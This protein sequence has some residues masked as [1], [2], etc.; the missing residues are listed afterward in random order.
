MQA[1]GS[2]TKTKQKG[3]KEKKNELHILKLSVSL[4]SFQPLFLF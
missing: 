4:I 1:V 2:I 3:K